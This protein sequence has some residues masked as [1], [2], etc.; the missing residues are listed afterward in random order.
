MINEDKFAYR[1][2][3]AQDN[4]ILNKYSS[5][6]SNFIP[7]GAVSAVPSMQQKVSSDSTLPFKNQRRKTLTNQESEGF[8]PTTY[9]NL[10]DDDSDFEVD[11]V[12]KMAK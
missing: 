3:L 10:M 1:S 8:S 12:T 6:N 5:T 2:I 9:H 4:L 11:Q 7:V